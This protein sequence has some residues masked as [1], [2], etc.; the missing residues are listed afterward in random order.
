VTG[1]DEGAALAVR[2]GAREPGETPDEPARPSGSRKMIG[3]RDL[4]LAI[5][6][7]VVLAGIF[8][9]SLFWH[10]LAFSLLVAVLVTLACV[11]SGRVLRSVGVELEVPVLL[12]ASLVMVAG[13]Y[14][15]RHA[16]QAVGI[17]VL[18]VGGVLWQLSDP[19]RRDVVRRLAT[20]VTF[21]L[22]IGFLASFAVLLITLP[23]DAVV[24]T[25]GVIGAAVFADIGAYAF[26][27]AFGRHRIA[28]S[29]S[30]NKTWEGFL[31]GLVVATLIAVLVLPYV[32]DLFTIPSAAALAVVC[33]TAAFLG[34]LVESM[35]KRDL[36]VKDLGDLLPGHGG[37]LDRV[38]GILFALPVGFY[39]IEV[40]TRS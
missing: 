14:Q 19:H 35:I 24:V 30:P 32:S 15:A 10:P 38:D 22:W 12:V 40:L 11:E 8:L 5:A 1:D 13:A 33:G 7:G 31:G 37:V 34:D 28:P 9:G 36:G 17:A 23:E 20:T 26:G 25:L 4:P 39:A 18:F 6:V 16:G 29:V 27:V 21:G 2:E 3:G